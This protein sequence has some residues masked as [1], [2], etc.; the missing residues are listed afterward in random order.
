MANFLKYI[1]DGDTEPGQVAGG[2]D[3]SPGGIDGIEVYG[4]EKNANANLID[5]LIILQ[6]MFIREPLLW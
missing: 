6:R 3:R 2:I 1:C 5:T 4:N